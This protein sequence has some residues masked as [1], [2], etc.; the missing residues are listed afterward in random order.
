MRAI[1]FSAMKIFSVVC[2]VVFAG[3]SADP[4]GGGSGTGSDFSIG[5]EEGIAFTKKQINSSGNFKNSD[6]YAVENGT[7]GLKLISGGPNSTE[8]KPVNWFKFNETGGMAQIFGSL[9]EVPTDK[10]SDADSGQPLIHAKTG[11][12]FVV[13]NNVGFGYTRGWIK[14]ADQFVVTFEFTHLD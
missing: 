1:V 3:C 13:K 5:G 12:G 8:P 9:A 11:N 10:P 7:K 6:I 4:A 14:Y 2:C